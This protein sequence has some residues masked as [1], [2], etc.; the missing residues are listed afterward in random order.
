MS[1]DIAKILELVNNYDAERLA[2]DLQIR[3]IRR[4]R[5]VDTYRKIPVL[6][7]RKANLKRPVSFGQEVA[8]RAWEINHEEPVLGKMGI[9][10]SE[11]VLETFRENGINRFFYVGGGDKEFEKMIFFIERGWTLTEFGEIE[12]MGE[13]AK[14]FRFI[15]KEQ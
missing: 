6:R 13:K 14:G 15:R 4:S 9:T 10:W 1:M 2:I 8:S 12:Y 5:E 11:D 3:E 7:N